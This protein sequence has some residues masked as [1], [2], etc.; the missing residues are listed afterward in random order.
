MW[1][2]DKAPDAPGRV[3]NLKEL[4]A[5]MDEFDSL[6]EFLEHI[7]LVMES[8]EGETADS[9]TL[10]TL[11]AAKGLE[12][13]TV[14]L[15]GWEDG[16]FPSQRSMDENG[17]KG[18]EEERR[19]A[20][21]GITR[22]RKKAYISYVAN[23]YMYGHWVNALPSR[24]VEELPPEHINVRAENGLYAPGRSSHWDSSG[25]SSGTSTAQNVRTHTHSTEK[26]TADGAL[27]TGDKVFHDKFGTG[28]IIHIDGQKLDI[29][30]EEEGYKRLM[31]SFVSKV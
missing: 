13:D 5:A 23:R 22:A 24:F 19:L 15:T 11:H 28:T 26:S 2:A 16:L 29:E 4:S 18:L 17:L 20:Y 10:M 9:I 8:K 6:Q 25:D 31:E 1:Q 21:V 3:E 12:F 27:K 30:F 7:A 14:F